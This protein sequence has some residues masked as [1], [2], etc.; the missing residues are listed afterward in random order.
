MINRRTT[1]TPPNDERQAELRRAEALRL[2]ADALLRLLDGE[3]VPLL[4]G[5]TWRAVERLRK[6]AA[7]MPRDAWERD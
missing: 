6:A 1:R 3:P 4:D 7:A 2:A 5:V